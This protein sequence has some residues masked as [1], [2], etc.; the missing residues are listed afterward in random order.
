MSGEEST[1]DSVV[2]HWICDFNFTNLNLPEFF[3]RKQVMSAFPNNSR[4]DSEL[5][6][7]ANWRAGR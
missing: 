1:K 6:E 7:R 3:Y 2:S 4:D 5:H